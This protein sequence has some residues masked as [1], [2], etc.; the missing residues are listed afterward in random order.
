MAQSGSCSSVK[1]IFVHI[2]AKGIA[3]EGSA[4]L[5][6]TERRNK[7]SCLSK[8]RGDEKSK[9]VSENNTSQIWKVV[10]HCS[11]SDNDNLHSKRG[12]LG[13]VNGTETLT[14]GRGYIKQPP[15]HGVRWLST[16]KRASRRSSRARSCPR[17]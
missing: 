12:P 3:S 1:G 17:F 5:Q 13:G 14:T 4:F 15:N 11:D 2:Y 16:E 10:P 8:P 9:A 7:C 6:C